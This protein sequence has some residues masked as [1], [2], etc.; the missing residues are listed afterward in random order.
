MREP[1][2]NIKALFHYNNISCF[3]KTNDYRRYFYTNFKLFKI[4]R[5]IRLLHV[6][7][8]CTMYWMSKLVVCFTSQPIFLSNSYSSLI[9]SVLQLVVRNHYV[10]QPVVIFEAGITKTC[11]NV[12]FYW[13]YLKIMKTATLAASEK[14]QCAQTFYSQMLHNFKRKKIMF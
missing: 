13:F 8:S 1:I 3:C 6:A 5:L 14:V 12:Y 4:V 7:I 10:V 2:W 9:T 11:E